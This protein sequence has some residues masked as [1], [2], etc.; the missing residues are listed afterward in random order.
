MNGRLGEDL[1]G[2]NSGHQRGES[3]RRCVSPRQ[4]ATDLPA[5]DARPALEN[6]PVPGIKALRGGRIAF[7]RRSMDP[8]PS[9]APSPDSPPATTDAVLIERCLRGEPSAWEDVIERY[10]RL[11]FSIARSYGLNE[12]DASDVTQVTFQILLQSLG[13]L[14]P[15][16]RLGYWLGSVARRHTWRVLR[17]ARREMPEDADTLTARA[18]A[19]GHPSPSAAER[20]ELAEWLDHGLAQVDARCRRLLARLYLD[21]TEPA[22]EEVAKELGLPIGSI[23][24]TRARC[25]EK[26]RAALT[27]VPPKP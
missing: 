2:G 10:G 8:S 7:P 13:R 5:Y 23:G 25:L 11:V 18:E 20:W 1:P 12:A 17:R 4:P 14:R 6:A 3:S 26:V 24:P 19:L 9:S 21:P 22:Y 15:D 16:S 27:A